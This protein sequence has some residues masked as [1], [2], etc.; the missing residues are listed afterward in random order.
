M[1]NTWEPSFLDFEISPYTGLTRQSWID[2]GEYLLRG[3]FKHIKNED[4][5]VIV[6]RNET[7][8]TYP[9]FNVTQGRHDAEVRAEIFEGLTRSFFIASVIIHEKPDITINGIRLRDYYKKQ[10]LRSLCDKKSPYYVGTYDELFKETDQNNPVCCFQQTVETC[11]LVIGLSACR[12]EIWDD[13]TKDEKKQ[14]AEFIENYAISPTVPQNWRLFNMLDLA[15]L[16]KEGF[17]IDEKI[18]GDHTQAILNYYVGD[19][20]YRDGQSFDYYSSWAFNVYAP[21]WCKWY[22]YERMPVAAAILENNSNELMKTYPDFFD[23][24]GYTNMWGRSNIY[25][26]AATSPFAA[27]LMLQKSSINPGLARRISSQ[28]LLQFLTRDD[29]L[30]DGIPSLGFYGQFMPLVQGYSCAESV[31]WLGKA[32]LCLELPQ[33]HPFW[34]CKEAENSFESLKKG[35]VKETFLKGPALC[36]TNH[37][38]NQTTILRSAKVVK[39]IGD[40]CGLWNYGKLCYSSKFPWES[41]SNKMVE[42]MQYVLKDDSNGEIQ[43]TNAIFL[44]D[45]EDNVLYRRAFFNYRLEDEMHWIQGMQLADFPVSYGIFRVDKLRLFKRPVTITLGSFGFPDNDISIF[46]KTKVIKN[47]VAAGKSHENCVK[48]SNVI[49]RDIV[50]KSVI[51]KGYDHMHHEKQLAFTIYYG[52]DDIEIWHS[53]GTNPDSKKSVVLYAVRKS[54]NLYDASSPYILLSQTITKESHEDFE[55]DE[56]FSLKSISLVDKW[57]S[58]AYGDIGVR[59]QNGKKVNV[60]FE[61]KESNLSI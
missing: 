35:E 51:L 18:M 54:E 43:N 42:S 33:N 4:A 10:I 34:T 7:R 37:K 19:G 56:L 22:G 3:I 55:E 20:W 59:L 16:Y 12:A 27:N 46:T 2:A 24:D 38:D 48:K 47:A 29:F 45:M 44:Q 11:A 5:P 8:I 31:Y 17:A 50:A 28:S 52:W 61:G 40:K 36:F 32:F 9:H 53:K 6:K 41:S 23:G 60:R 58:G 1:N 39:K 30:I 15:F 21:I 25:R 57:G 14:I 26:N 49:E 13:Y